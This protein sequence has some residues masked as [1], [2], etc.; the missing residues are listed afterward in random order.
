MIG[1]RGYVHSEVHAEGAEQAAE[2]A[3]KTRFFWCDEYRES[4]ARGWRLPFWGWG[5]KRILAVCLVFGAVLL[6]QGKAPVAFDAASLKVAETGLPIANGALQMKGGPGTNDS[7][8]MSWGRVQLR[9]LLMK[10]WEVEDYRIVG[11]PPNRGSGTF[12]VTATMPPETTKQ[13]FQLMLQ[14]LLIERFQ[15]KLHHE[16]R[17]YPG[18]DL[19]VAPG[20]AKL[21][22]VDPD[23]PE[24][25]LTGKPEYDKDGFMILPPGHSHAIALGAE[26]TH[27]NFQS[28]TLAE[29]MPF[30][31]G[32]ISDS[33]GSTSH[34]ADKTS[35]TGTYDFRLAFNP[36]ND[37]STVVAR[38]ESVTVGADDSALPDLFKAL[39][40]QMGLKLVKSKGFPLD[41]I[42]IDHAEKIPLEN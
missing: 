37:D 29:F 30:L 32:F 3:E 11:L 10:A 26:G 14:N 31:R 18:Y 5:M 35:L 34:V 20:G 27:A 17:V 22:A 1:P 9:T 2:N 40:K 24:L 16:T 25:W 41:T 12:A 21:K 36:R 7:G 33:V 39:E 8:R 23:A 19:V 38:G 6:G 13:Q 4:V 15:I 28:W 42:V